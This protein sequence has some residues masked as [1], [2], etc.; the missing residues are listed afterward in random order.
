MKHRLLYLTIVRSAACS[1]SWADILNIDDRSDTLRADLA[2]AD[3]RNI[4]SIAPPVVKNETIT[5][6]LHTA[7]RLPF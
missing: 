2:F 1:V 7:A 6:Y 4:G 5:V 3:S